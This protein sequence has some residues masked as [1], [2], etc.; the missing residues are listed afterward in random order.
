M[1]LI[2]KWRRPYRM[3]E[4]AHKIAKLDLEQDRAQ[5]AC[6]IWYDGETPLLKPKLIRSNYCTECARTSVGVE[7]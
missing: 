6:G 3:Q 7:F 2:G 4:T 1:T 5:A